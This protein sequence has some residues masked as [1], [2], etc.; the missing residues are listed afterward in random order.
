[1]AWRQRYNRLGG[2]LCLDLAVQL[3]RHQAAGNSRRK[4]AVV[5]DSHPDT[6]PYEPPEPTAEPAPLQRKGLPGSYWP[7]IVSA[8][9]VL[10]AFAIPTYGF[11][12]PFMIAVL[13]GG[14]RTAWI[15]NT[16]SQVGYEAVPY[17]G[18]LVISFILSLMFQFVAAIT[19]LLVCTTGMAL[20]SSISEPMVL[21]ISVLAGLATFVALVWLSGW[22]AISSR[23]IR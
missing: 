5:T 22:V 6:N 9:A 7:N 21:G 10:F 15:V 18:S 11:T 17:V 23:K 2:L 13:A 3:D 12:L 4:T 16:C 19:Y 20:M 8:T 1:M 14:V